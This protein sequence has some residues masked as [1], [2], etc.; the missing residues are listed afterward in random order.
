MW[1]YICVQFS[2]LKSRTVLEQIRLLTT[3]FS[4]NFETTNI[5]M[6]A[7]ANLQTF[8]GGFSLEHWL[9][10]IGEPHIEES[11]KLLL[12]LLLF[13]YI[14]SKSLRISS[15]SWL[16]GVLSVTFTGR[17]L[18]FSMNVLMNIVTIFKLRMKFTMECFIPK[19]W[20]RWTIVFFE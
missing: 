2:T 13:S 15:N 17:L 3:L 8:Y 9:T 12:N 1:V 11:W 14:W 10:Y 6:S 5:M 4:H 16:I 18:R 19:T 7:P 20:N